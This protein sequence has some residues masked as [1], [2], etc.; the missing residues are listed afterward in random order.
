MTFP[1]DA[2]GDGL[3]ADAAPETARTRHTMATMTATALRCLAAVGL[4][5]LIAVSPRGRLAYR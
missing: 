3:P 2:L 5:V 1:D 4:A